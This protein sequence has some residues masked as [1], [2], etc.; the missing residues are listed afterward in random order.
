MIALYH[1]K[2]GDGPGTDQIR[3]KIHVKELYKNGPFC[4]S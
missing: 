2:I 3:V 4:L 1:A